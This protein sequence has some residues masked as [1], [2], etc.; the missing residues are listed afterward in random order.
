[1]KNP[2]PDVTPVD[3]TSP[4]VRGAWIEKILHI[5]GDIAIA[6]PLVRGAWIEKYL[7]GSI[8]CP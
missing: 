5:N 1:M 6:S 7:G 3:L 4:L 8:R 2:M